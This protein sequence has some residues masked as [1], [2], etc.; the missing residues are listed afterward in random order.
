MKGNFGTP[1]LTTFRKKL[2]QL[3]TS[4]AASSTIAEQK[5]RKL[6]MGQVAYTAESAEMRVVIEL[7]NNVIPKKSGK[8]ISSTYIKRLSKYC[9]ISAPMDLSIDDCKTER[10]MMYRRLIAFAKN[11][12]QNRKE[13]I[14]SLA[15][16]IAAEGNEK[17]SNVV[18]RLICNEED[19]Q[20]RRNIEV[21]VKSFAG[22][23]T[24]MSLDDPVT[25]DSYFTTDKERI[26]VTLKCENE[27]KY[28]LAYS[29]PFLQ[30][31]L[32]SLLGQNSLTPA[33]DV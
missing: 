24:R 7:W 33:G 4:V 5:C 1:V 30:E 23:T 9:N 26:E 6:K 2:F 12:K 16:A 27:K 20:S 21:V 25:G 31:P 14:D 17:K 22:A 15:D 32:L 8:N 10:S 13:F 28:K 19:T 29:S 18:R 3:D 11:D